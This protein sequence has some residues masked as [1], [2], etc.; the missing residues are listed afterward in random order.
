MNY[1]EDLELAYQLGDQNPEVIPILE[2]VIAAADVYQDIEVG[3]EAR[4][5]MIEATVYNGQMKKALQAFAWLIKNMKK[6]AHLYPRMIF[7][8]NTNGSR[9]TLAGFWRFLKNK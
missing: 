8:G 7:Y 1:L 9:A 2:R 4:D 6:K 3:V 5:L